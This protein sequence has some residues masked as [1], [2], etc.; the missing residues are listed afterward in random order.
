MHWW[1]YYASINYVILR[2]YHLEYYV[3]VS[4]LSREEGNVLRLVL[5]LVNHVGMHIK[6]SNTDMYYHAQCF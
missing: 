1:K 5:V 3:F 4:R 2:G 6:S